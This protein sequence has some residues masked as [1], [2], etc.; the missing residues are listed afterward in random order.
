MTED[1]FEG[2][3][4]DPPS[5]H[6]Y[7]YAKNN[8][9]IFVDPTGEVP[10]L[11]ELEEFFKGG[12]TENTAE[13]AAQIDVGPVTSV[14]LGIL[15]AAADLTGA[16]VG[17]IN[18]G[19][20][21]VAAGIIPE[22]EIGRQAA[23]DLDETVT[24]FKETVGMIVENPGAVG[25]AIVDGVIETGKGVLEGD[26]RA[27]TQGVSFVAQLLVPG[28]KGAGAVKKVAGALGTGA[29]VTR[30]AAGEAADAAKRS[31]G[32]LKQ[33]AN[34]TRKAQRRAKAPKGACTSCPKTPSVATKGRKPP[35][36]K[37]F[38]A[39]TPIATAEGDKPIEEIQVGELVW[40][41]NDKT[42]EKRLQRVVELFVT[43]NKETLDLKLVASN[44]T[45]ETL[46]VTKEHPFWGIDRGWVEAGQLSEGEAIFTAR[47]GW[48]KVRQV[49]GSPRGPETVFNFEVA[50]DH[51]YFVGKT[52]AWVHNQC[53]TVSGK[54]PKGKTG[55]GIKEQGDLG[56][57]LILAKLLRNKT[58]VEVL[59][60]RISIQ[61]IEQSSTTCRRHPHK[62]KEGWKGIQ[63]RSEDWR[64]KTYSEPAR[65]GLGAREDGR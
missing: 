42:G 5:L 41:R 32:R 36:K 29:R 35:A 16:A 40:A 30:K 20:N 19:A 13:L 52:E 6:R 12:G 37:C 1:P 9:T 15:G 43:P 38:V 44:G 3:S 14:L 59:G 31:L 28:P 47:D 33:A 39:G 49:R 34:Q 10:V 54:K 55:L 58:K 50:E 46:G 53:K 7:L 62:K 27:I 56:E 21:A 51:T 61:N 2:V 25:T 24:S 18:T 23:K 22:T 60:T 26:P 65:E 8:P 4:T 45:T 17:V 11:D 63:H 64:W 57:A 48:L